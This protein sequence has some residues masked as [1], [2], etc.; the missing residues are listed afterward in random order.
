MKYYINGYD[1]QATFG[2]LITNGTNAFMQLPER[3]PSVQNDFQNQNGIDIDLF[4]PKFAARTFV[5]NCVITAPTIEAFKSQYFGLFQLLKQQD[6]YTVFNDWLNMMIYLYFEK[7]T[8]IS[9]MYSTPG[10]GFGMMF[11]LQFGETDPFGNL[12]IVELV[13]DLYNILVP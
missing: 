3:K 2:V 1:L 11:S 4:E 9:N 7:Q 12:P 13:D 5:F 8:N 10:G 6:E